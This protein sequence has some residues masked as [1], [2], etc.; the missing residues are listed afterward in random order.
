MLA[1]ML[2]VNRILAPIET[3][4][5]AVRRMESGAFDTRVPVRRRDELGVL[6]RSFNELAGRLQKAE[7]SRRALV[8]DI[9]HELRTPLTNVRGAIESLQDGVV[10]PSAEELDAIHGDVLLLE[11]LIGDLHELS[12]ADAGMLALFKEPVDVEEEIRA[13]LVAAGAR[14]T[15]AAEAN[16]PRVEC[17]PARLRQIFGNVLTNALRYSPQSVPIAVTIARDA[18]SV[19]VSIADAGPGFPPDQAEAIFE[20]FHRVD[21]SRSR[22]TGGTGLGLAIARQLVESHGGRIGAYV[23]ERGGATVWFTLPLTAR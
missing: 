21:D 7:E 22:D 2:L 12:L 23:N 4:T 20:R 10:A 9:A 19:K 14:A 13:A 18:A 16:L 11:R 15:L 17:D 1:A 6:A 3:L 8:A 5:A